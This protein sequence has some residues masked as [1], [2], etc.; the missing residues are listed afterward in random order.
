MP[1][2][3]RPATPWIYPGTLPPEL[4]SDQINSDIDFR[5]EQLSL[6]QLNDYRR[7]LLIYGK[8]DKGS[9]AW[10]DTKIERKKQQNMAKKALA[11]NSE[12][13]L[14]LQPE[15]Q[16]QLKEL[17]TVGSISLPNG[18]V[19][20]HPTMRKQIEM[21][22]DTAEQDHR[23][24]YAEI[25]NLFSRGAHAEGRAVDIN[26]YDG[27]P[28]TV[29]NQDYAQKA[30]G[31]YTHDLVPGYHVLLLPRLPAD[32]D[33]NPQQAIEDYNNDHDTPTGRP[34]YGF[35]EEGS[36]KVPYLPKLKP[37]W[38]SAPNLFLRRDLPKEGVSLDNGPV[39]S[40]QFRNYVTRTL[41]NA[42]ANP[43]GPSP[44]P[45]YRNNL[46]FWTTNIVD[47]HNRG[48]YVLHIASDAPDHL[49]H[50][51]CSDPAFCKKNW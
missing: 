31:Q 29:F 42:L 23:T 3:P 1:R 35:Y 47:A 19:Q 51:V 44:D 16:K 18:A 25:M 45:R 39:E 41:K 2:N 22:S 14:L 17:A 34:K 26:R 12:K 13:S 4:T 6:D 10:L 36:L 27:L 46:D 7:Q 15:L 48:A 50:S 32:S 43:D 33:L 9:L 5:V 8:V 21:I 40:S 49:H 11:A 24:G 28:I 20:I 30:I 38:K 37:E